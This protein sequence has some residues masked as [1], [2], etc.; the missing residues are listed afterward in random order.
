ML[1]DRTLAQR[2]GDPPP[3]MGEPW[4][5][6]GREV[7]RDE[8]TV[9]AGPEHCDWQDAA[10]LSGRGITGVFA[11]DPDGT[12]DIPEVQQGF[13]AGTS[14]PAD[15]VDT[16]YSQ[17]PVHLWTA[18]SDAGRFVYAVLGDEV[19]RWVRMPGLCA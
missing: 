4:Q 15:A 10:L 9:A 5:R 18:A 13:R 17:G 16:G 1:A 19:E 2:F 8:L 6:E 7:L 11:R 14:L 12:M 3:G